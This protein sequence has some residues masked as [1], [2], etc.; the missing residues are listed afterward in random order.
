MKAKTVAIVGGGIFGITAALELAKKI[1][2]TVFEKENDIFSGATYVN[3]YRHHLGYHYPRSIETVKECRESKKDFEGV[4]GKA[5]VPIFP[6]YYSVSKHDS[7]TSPQ[8]YLNFCHRENLPFNIEYPDKKFLDPKKVDVSI[9][10][11]ETVYDFPTLKRIAEKN[12]KK[13]KNIEMRLKNLVTGGK[14]NY[15]GGKTIFVESRGRRQ[16]FD[17]DYLINATYSNYN[18]L[19]KAFGLPRKNLQFELVE[20]LIIKLPVRGKI[21]V[22]VMD[23]PFTCILPLWETGYFTLGHVEAS[24]HQRETI[25]EEE[26]PVVKEWGRIRSKKEKIIKDSLEFLPILKDATFIRSLYITRAVN[27]ENEIDDGRPTEI[28]KHGSGFFS[29][30]AGKIV[31]CITT[32]KELARIIN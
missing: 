8:D 32:A 5:I 23:G 30:F 15:D 3:Q 1:K 13:T 14:I 10:V 22:T 18:L 25:D 19:C 28:K 16:S 26:A 31:T 27:P 20:L 6:Y 21:G 29:V 24:V 7:K 4:F 17:F 2:V 9:K 11:P 12:I